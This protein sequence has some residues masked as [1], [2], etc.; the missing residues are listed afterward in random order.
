MRKDRFTSKRV[1][2]RIWTRGSKFLVSRKCDMSFRF[3]KLRTNVHIFYIPPA[4]LGNAPAAGEKARAG[5][6][7]R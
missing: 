7:Q 1:T 6:L 2:A 4:A 3:E 5:F